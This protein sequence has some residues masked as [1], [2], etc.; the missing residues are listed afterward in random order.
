MPMQG[1]DVIMDH[2]LVRRYDARGPRY[3]SYPTADRFIEAFDAASYR[4]WLQNRS[5]GGLSKA[6]GLYVHLP[7]CDT[8]CYYCACNKVVTRDHSRATKYLD[9]LDREMGLLADDLGHPAVGNMH[10]G[11]GTPTFLSD[12]EIQALADRIG[13]R[14]RIEPGAERSIE[15]DPRKLREGTVELLAQLGFN[16][17]SIGVQDFD[18]AVQR[19]VNRVQSREQTWLAIEQARH[20]GF[21]SVNLDLMY[22]LP[23]QT[24]ARFER[25]LGTVIECAPD[26]IALYNYAHLPE[27]FKSQRRIVESELP[28]ADTKL[29]LLSMAIERLTSAGYVYVG[30]DHFARPE[31]ELV[32]A[33]RQGRL[34]RNFQG[35]STSGDGDMIAIGVSAISKIGP[36]YSQ[37]A[38]VI[39][40]YC[41]GLDRGTLPVMRGIELSADDLVRRAVIQ[42]LMC[43]FEL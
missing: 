13:A 24:L 32:Q 36:A 22:G 39:D 29:R 23:R 8:V 19:A 18:P 17:I 40:D 21:K 33:L 10:W 28:D 16:R 27:V 41:D 37:N 31:D 11:G 26:R 35:Y 5:V 30:M 15:V 2:D 7:F 38:K 20:H 9:Y 25:T 6:V 1:T 3:T 43:H 34:T 4:H 42:S 12:A 14:F